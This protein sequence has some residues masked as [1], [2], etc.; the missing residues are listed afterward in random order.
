VIT[1]RQSPSHLLCLWPCTAP[2][3][4][5]PATVLLKFTK[6]TK[7]PLP[8]DINNLTQFTKYHSSTNTRPRFLYCVKSIDQ[9]NILWFQR[10]TELRKVRS[11]WLT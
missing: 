11:I 8:F 10:F 6:G 1:N 9:K 2:A 7:P 4:M 5:T 3:D